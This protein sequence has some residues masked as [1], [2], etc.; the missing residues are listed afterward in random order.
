MLFQF[1]V[2]IVVPFEIAHN[3]RKQVHV[4]MWHR[5]TGIN[6]ILHGNIQRR[7]LVEIL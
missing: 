2:D 6:A 3:P 4:N 5:L 7:R 1:F